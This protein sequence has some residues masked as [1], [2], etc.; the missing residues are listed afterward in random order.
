MSASDQYRKLAAELRAKSR[1]EA[2]S[3]LKAELIHL[4][5]CYVRLASKLTEISAQMYRTSLA[6]D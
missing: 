3:P 2:S 5:Q 6:R 4:A 1:A